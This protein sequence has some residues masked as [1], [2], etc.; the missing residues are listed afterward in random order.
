MSSIRA[1][2]EELSA[3]GNDSLRRLF[4]VR[5]DLIMPGVPDFAA[6]AARA[7]ARVSLQ[8]ALEGLTKPELQVLEALVLTTNEDEGRSGSAVELRHA[9]ANAT[10]GTLET[11]LATLSQLALLYRAD[12]PDTIHS[13]SGS[14]RRYYQPVARVREVLG[15]YPAGLGRPY[16]DL[17]TTS[18]VFA[19]QA[20][21]IVNAIA[22][23]QPVGQQQPV[24]HHIAAAYALERWAALPEALDGAPPR[25]AE[26]LAKFAHWPVGAVP[27]AAARIR[28][29]K[30]TDNPIDWLLTHGLLVP[31]DDEHVELPRAAGLA[32]RGGRIVP[33]LALAPQP[34]S[35]GTTTSA[36]RRNA[37]L[38]AIADVLRTVSALAVEAAERPIETLRSGGVGTREMR[39]LTAAL[40]TDADPAVFAL[41]L[42][43]AANVLSLD[44]DT[45]TWR[46]TGAEAW[47]AL[48]RPEQWLVLATVW[49]D[50]P[51]VA[52]LAMSAEGSDQ[53]APLSGEVQRSDAP[54]VRRRVLEV[55]A[56]LSREVAQSNGR[57]PVVDA[58]SVRARID[59][60]QPRLARRLRG[61]LETVLA[62]AALLG[63]TGSGALTGVG[64]AVLRDDFDA[65]RASL[66]E[67]LP[68]GVEK[69]V[70]QAD[71]TAV[72]PGYLDPVLARRLALLAD[73]EGRGPATIYRFSAASLRRALD[74]GEDA[75]SIHA[76]LTEHASTAVPQPLAYLIDDTA[77]RHGRIRVG[78]AGSFIA[79]DDE[80]ALAGVLADPGARQLG[81]TQIA[82]TVLVS[83]A[84]PQ[85]VAGVL[86]E[87]GLSPAVDASLDPV[88]RLRRTTGASALPA[89]A[90]RPPVPD[91]EA[92][93]AQLAILRTQSPVGLVGDEAAPA[94][95]I[96][97]LQKA[98]RL[99]RAVR[100]SIVD[101]L[102]NSSIEELRPVS[103]SAG[104]VRVFDPE[105]ETERV[106]SVHRI[107]DVELA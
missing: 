97:T 53:L 51:R 76:F 71:L 1:L 94:M 105:R 18:P 63:F 87:L 84:S 16:T 64:E 14:R 81:L 48:S 54:S 9:V 40:R 23:L 70:L 60:L 6:L 38:G 100:L 22:A 96:E 35:L 58:E 42:A 49:L 8:R 13:A 80:A 52:S 106:L 72:A 66:A 92:V 107:I 31:L 28:P 55:A 25:T 47:L 39:R 91:A 19:E 103:I 5:P 67:L 50:T 59:W 15:S 44:P 57:V 101:A 20:A 43:A 26:V 32:L 21:S 30:K 77:A 68:A 46:A 37:A 83:N 85:E 82:P 41:E 73:P 7:C 27:H 4:M 61:L 88:V 36:L 17:A 65:A 69:V 62:E 102:G 34:A 29:G 78:R 104:R 86:R 74:A 95:G 56:A 90:P 2:A 79:S 12:P 75:A 24:E 45:S 98:I 11:I 99:K 10:L 33:D 3:R 89:P 93:E